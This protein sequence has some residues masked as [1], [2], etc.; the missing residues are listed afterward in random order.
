V[1]QDSNPRPFLYEGNA[2]PLSY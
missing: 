2:L 1:R